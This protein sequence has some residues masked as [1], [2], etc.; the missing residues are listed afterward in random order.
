MGINSESEREICIRKKKLT[1]FEC[2][3]GSKRNM[4]R[5]A[6]FN[7]LHNKSKDFLIHLIKG[8]FNVYSSLMGKGED[9]L[10]SIN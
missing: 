7:N 2:I 10:H 5:K 4:L 1:A 6:S 8:I 9:Y 3:I